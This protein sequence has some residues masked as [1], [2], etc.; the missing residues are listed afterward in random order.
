ML[1]GSSASNFMFYTRGNRADYDNWA[2]QGND[3]WDWNNV[4]HYFKKSERLNDSKILNGHTA[5]LH[6]DDGY[7]GVSR[8]MWEGKTDSAP[9]F[10]AF[11]ENGHEYHED[12]NGY[13]QNGYSHAMFTI[14]NKLRQSTALAFLKPAGDRHNLYLLKNTRVRKVIFD[15]SKNAVG[16]EIKLPNGKVIHVKAGKEV[17]LSAGA[18]SSPQLLMLSGVGPK[19]HLKEY[20]IEVIIDSPNVGGNLQ[21]HMVVPIIL[22][23][24]N[25]L[26]SVVENVDTV[27]NLDKFPVPTM[28]GF[29]SVD[30]NQTYPDYQVTAVPIPTAG[31]IHTLMCSQLFD[32]DDRICAAMGK[33]SL[34]KET[35]F[36]LL[37]YLHPQSRGK[38]RLRNADPDETAIVN[39]GYFGNLDDLDNFA[40][41]VE[42]YTSVVNTSLLKSVRSEVADLRVEQCEGLPF[43]SHEYWKCYVLNL[44]ATMYHPS[45]TCAM[46]VEGWGV[47]DARLR[48]RGAGGL[49][50]VDA[51]VMPTIVS[52][53]TN[54]P[55]IMIA[56]KAADM[57]KTDH[58][59]A[60]F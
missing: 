56:E 3:G 27:N 12:T 2:A 35:L 26:L 5:D 9:Y 21:D 32:L 42:D 54:A 10:Q 28:M 30:R 34:E 31:L 38:V 20:N 45:G 58:G 29:A 60:Y 46:G 19:D 7:L 41:C 1:G 13:H 22:T 50:V 52:G 18:L 51:S 4:L 47:V 53:N 25:N 40:T 24:K 15:K 37:T 16:T 14:D 44:A 59:I 49:R 43:G 48:V 36:A 8:P 17:I 23:G 11:E 6:S 39:T 33:Q 57:I 55:T